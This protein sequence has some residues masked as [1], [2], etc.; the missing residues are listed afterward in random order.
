MTAER[1]YPAGLPP[2]SAPALAAL[3]R[4]QQT[5]VLELRGVLA[6]EASA[7]RDDQTERLP[8]IASEKDRLLAELEEVEIERVRL[9][10]NVNAPDAMEDALAR[11]DADGVVARRWQLLLDAVEECARMNLANGHLIAA[12]QDLV[13]RTLN[14]LRGEPERP[15]VYA[16]NGRSGQGGAGRLLGSG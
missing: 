3:I 5:R 13:T 14:V 10:C 7:L 6:R 16:A 11:A 9:L 8:G 12:R 2:T 1:P 4:D 15:P